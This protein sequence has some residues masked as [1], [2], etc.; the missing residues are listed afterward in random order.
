MSSPDSN[1]SSK[2]SGH[3]SFFQLAGSVLDG[4]L[5]FLRR[6]PLVAIC[7]VIAVVLYF[8]QSSQLPGAEFEQFPDIGQ[9]EQP[10]AIPQNFPKDANPAVLTCVHK[11]NADLDKSLW[12]DVYFGMEARL[13]GKFLVAK[14]TEKWETLSDEKQKTVAQF[15]VDTWVQNGRSLQILASDEEMEEVIIKRLPDDQTVAT[16]KP[17]A[18]LYIVQPQ[19]GV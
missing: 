19:T 18:G 8:R 15:I 10:P 11:V 14:V 13:D 2:P 12:A 5:T 17:S 16:W 1:S 6:A 4:F 7:G 9:M 3:R